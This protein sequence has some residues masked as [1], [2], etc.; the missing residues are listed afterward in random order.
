M[1][2]DNVLKKTLASV[3]KKVRFQYMYRNDHILRLDAGN[4]FIR[5]SILSGEP[6]MI[7]R[8][9]AT[10]SRCISKWMNGQPFDETNLSNIK[11]LSGVFPNTNNQVC[12]FCQ[13]YTNSL[14]YADA[15]A[16]WGVTSERDIL[17][18]YTKDITF[19]DI[20]SLEPYFYEKPW[21]SALEGKKI[22]IIHPFVQTI[23]SQL[24]R[25]KEIFS[26]KTIL[27]E[28]GGVVYIRAVQSLGGSDEYTSWTTALQYMLNQ[29]SCSEFDLAI[30]GAGAYGLPLAAYIKKI[31]KQSIL[32]AGA[33]QLLFGIKGKRWEDRK[34]Y[35]RFINDSW[36]RPSEKETPSNKNKVEGGSYW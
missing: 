34:E 5:D 33:T 13:I 10:E 12:E 22:L 20:M 4:A 31:G 19:L 11:Q 2:N 25:R 6:L 26:D 9:G 18:K 17:K 14:Q 7:G 21:S 16:V 3:Y 28:F 1:D 27:P 24:H 36:V 15:M 35:K 32:M 29:I 23:K 8:L 30:I